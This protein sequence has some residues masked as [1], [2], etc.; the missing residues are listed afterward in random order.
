MEFSEVNRTIGKALSPKP[1]HHSVHK[2]GKIGGYYCSGVIK[3]FGPQTLVRGCLRGTAS[4]VGNAA[5]AKVL[6]ATVIAPMVVPFMTPFAAYAAGMA[7]TYAVTVAGNLA[8]KVLFEKTPQAPSTAKKPEANKEPGPGPISQYGKNVVKTYAP[9]AI[10]T[11]IINATTRIATKA[12]K[13]AS[14]GKFVGYAVAPIITP[15]ASDILAAACGDM[16]ETAA[17]KIYES[18]INKL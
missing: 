8:A 7:A 17:H 1:F 4:V 13:D 11:G 2:L 5:A 9:H 12:M 16:L 6:G 15:F 10:A 3:T 14:F 18:G